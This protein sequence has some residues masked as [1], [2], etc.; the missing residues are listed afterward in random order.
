MPYYRARRWR[1][2]RRAPKRGRTY[3][4]RRKYGGRGPSTTVIRGPSGIPDRMFVKLRHAATGS[5]AA[6]TS[7]DYEVISGNN[8]TS[9]GMTGQPYLFDQWMALYNRYLVYGAKL[10][11]IFCNT[12]AAQA[13]NVWLGAFPSGTVVGTPELLWSMPYVRSAVLAQEGSARPK[14]L[15]MYQTAR[16]VLGLRRLGTDLYKYTGDATAGPD[17]EWKFHVYG[18]ATDEATGVTIRVIY[19][20][21]YYVMLHE[22]KQ[23]TGS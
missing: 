22:R 11:V 9:S 14:T 12:S 15:G 21:K 6:T 23:Q 16:K 4:P 13:V 3:K 19:K 17:E 18:Q 7:L 8:M 10:T 5:F 2:T 20:I 1:S